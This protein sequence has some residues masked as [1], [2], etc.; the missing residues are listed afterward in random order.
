M[1]QSKHKSFR[2]AWYLLLL[3]GIQLLVTVSASAQGDSLAFGDKKW[4]SHGLKGEIYSLSSETKALP[5]FDTM[6]AAGTIYTNKIDV[7]ARNWTTGFPG[8]PDRKE[9]FAVVYT[10]TF[11]VQK[12]GHY[13]F[14]L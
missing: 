1:L 3:L 8:L 2:T 11:K 4:I 6:K 5:N 14:R 12:P 7:P 13:T 10:G 9:W